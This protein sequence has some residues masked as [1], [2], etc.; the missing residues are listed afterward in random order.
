ML[1]VGDFCLSTGELP[2]THFLESS[3]QVA[4]VEN[5]PQNNQITTLCAPLATA[6]KKTNQS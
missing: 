5:H 4:Y 2:P 6:S 3:G 1:L